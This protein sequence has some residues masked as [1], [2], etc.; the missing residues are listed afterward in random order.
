MARTIDITSKL[1]NSKPVIQIGEKSYPVDNTLKVVTQF[2][3]LV[4]SSGGEEGLIQGLRVAL[5]ETAVEELDLES[6][7]LK[8]VQV[9]VLAVMA[10]MQDLSY[11]EAEARF[12]K[13]SEA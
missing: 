4:V 7:T 8:S 3:R 9:I 6:L 10:A 11:E 13:F 1:D 2:N 12:R 5:G